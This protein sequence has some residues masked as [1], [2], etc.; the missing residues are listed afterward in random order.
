[1]AKL[2]LR[3]IYK[4]YPN[5]VKAVNDFNMEIEDK[6]F[7][8][9]VGPS[10]CGKST[11]L[12]MIAGL[13]EIT[14]GEL[15]IGDNVVNDSEPKDRDIAMVFQNYA[16]YPHMNVYDNMAFGLKLRHVPNDEIHKKVLWAAKILKLTDYLDR[17]P[18]EMS[19]GQRQRVSLGRAILR[20][21]KVFLLDEPLSNLD[22]KLRTE[23]RSE[24]SKL[25]NQLQTTFIY[26]THDQVEAMTMGTR[27]VVMKLGY[28]QQIDTPQ[29]LYNYPINKFVAGFIGTP[30]MNFF[31]ATMLRTDN[32]VKITF[33]YCENKLTVPFNDLLKVRPRYLNGKNHIIVGLRCENISL[34]PEIIK[35]SKNL[36]KVKVSHFEELGNETLVYGDMNMAGD[37][38]VESST[39]VIIKSYNGSLGLKQGD[40]IDAAFDL[41]KAQFFNRENENSISPRVPVENV[42]DCSIEKGVISFLGNSL[43][44]PNAIKCKDLSDAQLFIPTKAINFDGDIET[45][46]VDFE[47][48]NGVKLA[49]LKIKDRV[50]FA[51]VDKVYKV[52]EKVKIGFDFK[53][54][55]IKV[56]DKDVV[57]PLPVYD[58][59]IGSFTNLANNKK[60]FESIK[61]LA[62]SMVDKKIT[63]ANH[64]KMEELSALGLSDELIKVYKE[65][66]KKAIQDAK[67]ARLY[68]LGTGDMTKKSKKA[69]ADKYKADV[70][71]AK[72]TLEEKSTSLRELKASVAK[73]KDKEL[74][75]LKTKGDKI[76]EDFK[77]KSEKI[78]EY[79]EAYLTDLKN[80]TEHFIKLGKENE[81][82][83]HEILKNELD[84]EEAK[85]KKAEE[86]IKNLLNTETDELK[87]ETLKND[88]KVLKA[89]HNKEAE[90]IVFKS[91]I[92]YLNVNGHYIRSNLDINGKIVQALGVDLFKSNYRFEVEHYSYKISDE[93]FKVKVLEILDFGN[94]L[95][96]KCDYL[97]KEIY[98]SVNKNIKVNQDLFLTIDLEHIRLY[99]NKF[100]IR[101][102]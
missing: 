72:K 102:Y 13:E 8:V 47:E 3:H 80:G 101:L 44:L 100:D 61:I 37:G 49:H 1:M 88:L 29:N 35:K 42:F 15:Y 51:I 26:V 9:F 89:K 95:F 54:I 55:S 84:I 93:G 65:D 74:V 50:F 32:E 10:G 20:N 94:E 46:V 27:I 40:V 31:E 38:F 52:N 67:D 53:Q 16:L 62:K 63:E 92:F 25:H 57:V 77:V 66:Y 64:L 23:M 96:A 6:E 30:Q 14:A 12:R 43:K 87:K 18:K 76:N 21:P 11:T 24:I 60:S 36:M 98:V 56:N 75:V 28:V 2:S 68:A 59:Y 97:G 73:L 91:K 90:K 99:E 69:I 33:D 83:A 71:E 34:D 41:T 45:V 86:E 48:I 19:G 79:Y 17:K 82:A 70:A 39:R 5:G 85:Y 7:I 4:V 78:N 81:A 22:A 58:E